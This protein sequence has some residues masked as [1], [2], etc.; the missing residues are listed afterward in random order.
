MNRQRAAEYIE[1]NEGYRQHVYEDTEG[2]PT[3]GIG[4]NLNEGF[5]REECLLILKHRIGTF[6]SELNDR[7]PAYRRVNQVRKTVLL[8]MAYNLGVNGLLNFRKM[9]AALE[10]GD[11]QL[12]AKEMLDSRYAKQVKGRALRNARMMESGRWYDWDSFG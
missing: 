1:M 7:V 8:D 6:I 5:S 2:I 10:E 11:Y 4:F 12:A 9:L 3:I